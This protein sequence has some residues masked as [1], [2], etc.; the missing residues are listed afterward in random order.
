M[1]L[2]EDILQIIREYSRPIT[3]PDW[4]K[5]HKMPCERYKNIFYLMYYR[6][7]YKMRYGSYRWNKEIFSEKHLCIF[8]QNINTVS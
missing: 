8:D 1:E 5:L 4:R 3:R 2:P 7:Q 6:R